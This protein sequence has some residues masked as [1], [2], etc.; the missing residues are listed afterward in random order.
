MFQLLPNNTQ[1]TSSNFNIKN[2]FITTNNKEFKLKYITY[3]LIERF[4]IVNS[5]EQ[6]EKKVLDKTILTGLLT[7]SFNDWFKVILTCYNFFKSKVKNE[8]PSKYN[9]G[10]KRESI[11]KR[12]MNVN[13]NDD[14]GG[15]IKLNQTENV[16]RE[17]SKSIVVIINRDI[18]R[19]TSKKIISIDEFI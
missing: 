13:L 5:E 10:D 15:L 11:K 4:L 2:P 18:N 3:P 8:N 9:S 19:R 6:F 12:R 1:I 16:R 7:T 17:S 14:G